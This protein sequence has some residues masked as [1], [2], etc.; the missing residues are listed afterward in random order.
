MKKLQLLALSMLLSTA[1]IAQS[2]DEASQGKQRRGQGGQR[3][4]RP[5]QDITQLQADAATAI[6]SPLSDAL[7]GTYA[8]QLSSAISSLSANS[9]NDEVKAVR[10]IIRNIRVALQQ[11]HP[12]AAKDEIV[13]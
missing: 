4:G 7:V 13:A 8:Q 10:E 2:A 6:G 11:L 5:K 12:K 1:Y 9:T 3:Q